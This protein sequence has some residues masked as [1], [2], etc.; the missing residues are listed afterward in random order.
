MRSRIHSGEAP[1]LVRLRVGARGGSN[2]TPWRPSVGGGEGMSDGDTV[3]TALGATPTVASPPRTGSAYHA[4]MSGIY[5]MVEVVGTSKTSFADAV[6]NAVT[7]A[8]QTV[9]HMDW[10]E[11]IAER[12]RIA[13]GQVVEFQ[14]AVKIGF[15]IER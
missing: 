8:G 15:K 9:R 11:V 10:F 2:P 12:G 6:K 14:V 3:S 7:E 1:P 13:D 5:K 4:G